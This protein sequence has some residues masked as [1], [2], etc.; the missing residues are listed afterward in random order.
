M[1]SKYAVLGLAA[2]LLC[3]CTNYYMVKDVQTGKVFYTTAILQQKGQAVVFKEIGSGAQ[4]TLQNSK[5]T[6]ISKEQYQAA[7]QPPSVK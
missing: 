3:A 4:V 7:I 6:P 5:V 1:R 2:L